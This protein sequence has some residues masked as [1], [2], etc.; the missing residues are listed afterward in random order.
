[1]EK[2]LQD[3]LEYLKNISIEAEEYDD[4]E[5]SIRYAY[6]Y[7]MLNGAVKETIIDLNRLILTH[8]LKSKNK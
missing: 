7:G 5:L 3:L 2:D 8:Q 1:M 6:K 4:E